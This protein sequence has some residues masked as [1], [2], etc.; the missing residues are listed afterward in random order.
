MQEQKPELAIPLLRE[1]IS[2][3]PKN[4][5]AQANAGVLLFFQ[6][7]YADAMPRMRAALE[8]QPDLWKIEALLGIAEKRTGNPRQ[9]QSH[10]ERAFPNLDDRKIQIQ[11]GLE[12]LELDSASSELEKAAVG[13]RE[14]GRDGAAKPANPS[15]R[16][17]NCAANDVPEPAEHDDGRAGIRGNAHDHGRRTRASGG[18][19]RLPSRNI[20][21]PSG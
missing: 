9:A 6:G 12:L 3:D 20:A 19:S 16:I 8:L 21:R 1:I 2:L 10:L 5:N 7:N 4:V 14:A 18:S 15:R 13:R 11:A 17:S